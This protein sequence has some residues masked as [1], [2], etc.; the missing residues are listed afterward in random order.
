MRSSLEASQLRLKDFNAKRKMKAA[1][2]TVKAV[3]TMK[4]ALG[5]MKAGRSG[6]QLSQISIAES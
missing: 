6:S 3:N 4:A 1:V 5:A 2:N